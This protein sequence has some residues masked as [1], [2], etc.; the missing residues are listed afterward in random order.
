MTRAMSELE[1][2]LTGS[3]N[4]SIH[5]YILWLNTFAGVS[6]PHTHR[7][8]GLTQPPFPCL[9]VSLVLSLLPHL[10]S[11]VSLKNTFKSA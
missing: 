2:Q 9:V 11:P 3:V 7:R 5:S 4:C 6:A 8:Q 10:S 1:Q